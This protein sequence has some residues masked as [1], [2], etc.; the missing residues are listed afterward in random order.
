MME[1]SE[2]RRRLR[3]AIDDAKRRV[4]ERRG[5]KDDATRTWEQLL[6]GVAVPSFLAIASALT[7][8]GLRFKVLTPGDAV[9]LVPERG[10]EEFIELA[11]DTE[12]EEPALMLRSTRGRGRRMISAERPLRTGAAIAQVSE[13]EIVDALLAELAPFI[14]R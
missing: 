2:V 12:A 1:V 9:R 14:D 10:G 7:G 4:A 11:L 3:A 6:P 8:E 5:R 13:E